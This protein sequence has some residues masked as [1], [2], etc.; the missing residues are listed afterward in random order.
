MTTTTRTRLSVAGLAAALVLT[1]CGG[2]DD[3]PAE[4]RMTI[5]TAN[6]A[7]LDLFEEIADAYL[8]DHPEVSKIEFDPL[9]FEKYT[10][11]LTTQIA[12]DNAPDMAWILENSAPDFVSSGALVPLSDTLSETKGYELDDLEPSTTK[13]WEADGQ[14]YAYP[15]S[16][17]PFGV[18]VNNDL[19]DEAGQPSAAKLRES[20]DWNWERVI[21]AGAAVNDSTGEAGMVI[22]DFDYTGW[23]N[24]STMWT[25][26]DAE[27][28]S[29]DGAKCGFD[30]PE[31]EEA[32]TFLHDS[33]FKESAMPGPGTT[34]DF[35]A[36]EA[37]MTVTQISRASLLEKADFDWDLAPLP[38]GPQG[39]Y[40][41]IGQAGL[42]VLKLSQHQEE[43]T[44]FLAYMTN[45][46]N[47]AKLAAFFPPPRKS[48]LTADALAESN[49]L[50]SAE[51]LQAVVIDGIADGV[52]KPS[53]AGQDE[54]SETVR[55]E[56]D[57][58]WTEKADVPKVMSQVCDAIKPMLK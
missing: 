36:G 1:G 28:W 57:S 4:L 34:A 42:G 21:E 44:D 47:S 58:L 41:V 13:L 33:I 8:A 14:L 10:S 30:K 39:E 5:W 16:T 27:A 32:M 53:H 20:G 6:E 37:G 51:Q 52:V 35:F 56:L 29:A 12:G 55:A 48:Q 43:A 11:T 50:L 54:I 2:G 22:R 9:P 38:A 3:G 46:K 15:F 45:P 19:L 26:W 49:P 18:F 7:H 40:S 17:S 24:L 23:D 31:M 25:G